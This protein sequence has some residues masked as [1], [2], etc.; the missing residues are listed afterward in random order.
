MGGVKLSTG[1]EI[2]ANHGI[3]GISLTEDD[4]PLAEGYDGHFYTNDPYAMGDEP[5]WTHAERR[6]LADR[7]IDRWNWWVLNGKR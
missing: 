3:I 7:M 6:E 5:P 4:E 2:R 1:R